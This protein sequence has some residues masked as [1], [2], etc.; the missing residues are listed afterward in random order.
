MTYNVTKNIIFGLSFKPYQVMDITKFVSLSDGQTPITRRYR[1][2]LFYREKIST[3]DRNALFEGYNI[4]PQFYFQSGNLK[5]VTYFNYYYQWLQIFDK[6]TQHIFDGYFQ[7]QHYLIETVNRLLLID[8]SA[9]YLFFRYKFEIYDDWA[10][11]PRDDLLINQ[12]TQQN[13]EIVLGGSSL[14]SDLPLLGAFEVSYKLYK[15]IEDDYLANVYRQGSINNINFKAGFEY[16]FGPKLDIR[17]G[18]IYTDYNENQVWNYYEDFNGS[19]VTFGFGWKF[20]Q[21]ELST[22]AELGTFK[23]KG[24]ENRNRSH[25]NFITTLKQYL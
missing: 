6:P 13:H 7:A 4:R 25:F 1:G 20:N 18:Y 3:S 16:N 12:L 23:S 22:H 17:A 15:P 9:T 2:E 8:I 24:S 19:K 14:I 11:E 10:K 21:F 5:S